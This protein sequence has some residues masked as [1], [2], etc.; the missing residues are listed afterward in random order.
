VFAP[1]FFCGVV[2]WWFTHWQFREP[3]FGLI[4]FRVLGAALICAGVPVVLESFARFALQGVGTPA[5]PFPT[6]HLVVSGFYRFVRNP[7][8]ISVVSIV[9]GQGFLFGSL[10]VLEYGIVAWF[11][12]HIFVL[13]YEEPTLR[14]T[15]GDEYRVYCANVP[16]WIPRITPWFPENQ[17][18]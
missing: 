18:R 13:A 14:R 5:P 11:V 6:Q 1:G 8:Y 4:A 15:F 16:R 2:P 17:T 10:H 3:F 9:L 7:M 12:T